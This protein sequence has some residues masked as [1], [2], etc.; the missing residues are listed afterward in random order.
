MVN[1][2]GMKSIEEFLTC[3]FEIIFEQWNDPFDSIWLKMI[4]IIIYAI[5]IFASLI[6]L[7][8]VV[9]ETRGLFGHYRTLI[10]QLLS[11]LYGGVSIILYTLLTTVIFP[12]IKFLK[13]SKSRKHF[14]ENNKGNICFLGHG[15]SRKITFEIYWPLILI[16]KLFFVFWEYRTFDWYSIYICQ[17]QF[18]FFWKYLNFFWNVFGL[19]EKEIMNVFRCIQ[20]LKIM[21]LFP[22]IMKI[23]FSLFISLALS[24]FC[25]HII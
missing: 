5:E 9:H 12:N 23:L 13:F 24:S 8:F 11:Y 20:F 7:A 22:K 2:N 25:I 19:W 17:K 4:T 14:L 15:V 3:E 16:F 18:Q 6:M 21:Y 1:L 10:N